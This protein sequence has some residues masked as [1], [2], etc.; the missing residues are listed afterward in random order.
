[1]SKVVSKKDYYLEYLRNF[2]IFSE[3]ELEEIELFYS[4]MK[5]IQFEEGEIILREGEVGHSVLLL[6]DGGVEVSQALTLKR[7]DS[8]MDTREKGLIKLNSRMYPFFGEMCLFAKDDKRSATV[9][10]ETRCII[11]RIT[12]TDFYK[13]CDANPSI[14]YK[15]MRNIATVLS[16]RLRQANMN[17]MKLTTAF[18]LLVD[19]MT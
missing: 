6:L 3:L 16:D 17:I 10:A 19:E 2:S 11:G 5:I 18:S 7:D 1:M 12:K 8:D 13:I 15:V 9:R 14:G 4:V